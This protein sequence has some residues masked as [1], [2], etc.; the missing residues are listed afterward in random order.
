MFLLDTCVVSES[1]QAKPNAAVIQWLAEQAVELQFMSVVTLG[2][3]QF[4]VA[5]LPMSTRR[6]NLARWLGTVE[7]TFAGKVLSFDDV[8]A[9]RWGQL[10]AERPSAEVADSQIAA[11][12]LVHGLTLV[13]RNVKEF[14]FEGLDVFNPWES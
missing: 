9:R 3:L 11:T 1:T 6:E 7:Q 5:R 4:G 8:V 14:A 10:R 2:E 13:T 12:A